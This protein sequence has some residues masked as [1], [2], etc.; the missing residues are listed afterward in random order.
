MAQRLLFLFALLWSLSGRAQ[1]IINEVLYDPSNTALDGDANGDGTYDQEEDS[2]IEFINVGSFNYDASGLQ[3][4]DDTTSGSLKYTVPQGTLVPPNGALVVF[5]GGTPTGNFGGAIILTASASPD[6][7]NL[8]NSGEV[9]VIKDSNGQPILS[10]DSDALS[11]NPN[12]SYTRNPDISGAFE[13][14]GDNTPILFSPGTRIDGTPFDTVLVSPPTPVDV[15][16]RADLGQMGMGVNQVFVAGNFNGY[17]SN[18]DALTDPDGDDIWEATINRP[19]DTL[20]YLIYADGTPED[21]SSAGACATNVGGTWMRSILLNG[22]TTLDPYCWQSCSIC[23]PLATSITVG[24]AGGQTTIS[25]SGGSLQMEAT[26]LP[27]SANQQVSW[28]IDNNS[29]ATITAQGLLT[30]VGNGTVRVT[31]ATTDGSSLADFVDI[32]ITNQGI[33]LSEI[34]NSQIKVYPNPSDGRFY[35]ENLP[36]HTRLKVMDLQGR[37]LLE[38]DQSTIDL[39]DFPNGLYLLQLEGDGWKLVKRLHLQH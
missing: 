22:D 31:G 12:E 15:T 13:Q 37:V 27:A 28:S 35:L 11:N 6:G 32:T 8:N 1:L 34:L 18:C 14:H 16:F 4:W 25:T 20:H 3:I 9:I 7:L 24:G 33:G 10:F 17:C 36:A 29:I 5:G 30:A 2:F 38:A 23:L 19:E 21:M 26:I 39:Q